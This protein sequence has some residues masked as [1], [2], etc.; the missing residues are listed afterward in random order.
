M[1]STDECQN[2]ANYYEMNI[3]LYYPVGEEIVVLDYK[4]TT[5]ET[6]KVASILCHNEHY[7]YVSKVITPEFQQIKTK[8]D[9]YIHN[10]VKTDGSSYEEKYESDFD[11]FD[12]ITDY[13]VSNPNR[14][15]FIHG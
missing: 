3:M 10:I 14:H 9:S 2:I 15:I 6:E 12:S 8:F 5:V 11:T 7:Y 4:C 13:I 1:I